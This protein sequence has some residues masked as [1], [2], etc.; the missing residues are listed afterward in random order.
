VNAAEAGSTGLLTARPP[1]PTAKARLPQPAVVT[2]A[3]VHQ[4]VVGSCRGV[5]RVSPSGVSY[6]TDNAKDSFSLKYNQFQASLNHNTLD[7]KSDQKTYKFR[8]ADVTG[9]DANL[10]QLRKAMSAINGFRPK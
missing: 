5:L 1:A 6:A 9:N 7:I 8:A 4:H 10:P 3:V 2:F